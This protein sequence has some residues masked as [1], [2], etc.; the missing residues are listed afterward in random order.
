[1][2]FFWISDLLIPVV[3]TAIGVLFRYR[4]P[5]RI[6][7]LYGYRTHRS[8]ASQQA[9]D[10]AHRE[11]GGLCLRVGPAL[12]AFV[13]IAKLL[14]PL[15]PEILSLTLLPFSLAALIVPIFVMERRLKNRE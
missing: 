10:M 9:W 2:I 3:V 8:M 11:Y 15:A 14:V 12:I 1:M 13:V 7:S 6:N 5:R 4:P